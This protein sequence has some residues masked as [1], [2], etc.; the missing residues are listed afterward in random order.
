MRAPR[1][2]T[3]YPWAGLER[4][5]RATARKAGQARRALERSGLLE[6]FA[7]ALGELLGSEVAVSLRTLSYRTEPP[8][9]PACRLAFAVGDGPAVSV[10]AVEPALATAALG[11]L[12][13]RPVGLGSTDQALDAQLSGALAAIVIEAARRAGGTEPLRMA[14]WPGAG[15][16]GVAAGLTVLLDGRPYEAMVFVS[17]ADLAP[18]EAPVLPELPIA[19]C[20]V[21]GAATAEPGALASLR[22]GD[23]WLAGA[24]WWI[25]GSLAGRGLLVAPAGETGIAVELLPD[26]QL[27]VREVASVAVEVENMTDEISQAAVDAALEAP[28]V[29][30]VEMGAV[31]MTARQW[32]QLRAGDV[33]E[34]GKRI[35]EPVTLR[36]AGR[37]VAR[38]DLVD[39]EGELGVRIR[40][41]VGGSE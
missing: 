5:A 10:V 6:R 24:G 23:A 41:I 30:R 7:P 14:S 31:S 40:E 18:D 16:P 19:L 11:R 38:G 9:T 28:V 4:V 22:P 32:A 2:V 33:I 15:E 35:A 8:T 20:L 29:V 36:I 12:L 34:T 3:P 17:G 25:D 21:V 26:A 13:G 37:V 1:A 39:I 27:L